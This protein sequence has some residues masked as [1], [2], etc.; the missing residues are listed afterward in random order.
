MK[1]TTFNTFRPQSH[2]PR[3]GVISGGTEHVLILMRK[4]NDPLK[5]L[6]VS[7]RHYQLLMDIQQYSSSSQWESKVN[8]Q[9]ICTLQKLFFLTHLQL[10]PIGPKYRSSEGRGNNNEALLSPTKLKNKKLC[11]ENNNNSVCYD[12]CL[13]CKRKAKGPRTAHKQ[14]ISP[15]LR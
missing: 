1:F 8:R 14:N 7:L 4:F 13:L 2:R 5:A 11:C 15:H 3:C 9:L 10:N 6:N 12:F